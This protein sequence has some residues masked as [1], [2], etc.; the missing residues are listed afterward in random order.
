MKILAHDE[1]SMTNLFFSEVQRHDRLNAFLNLIEWRHHSELPFTVS[2][3]EIH[4]Q[5]NLSEFARPDVTIIIRDQAGHPHIIIV[6]VK[7][8]AYLDCC[9]ASNNNRFDNKFNSKLN[10][11]LTLR[12]RAMQSMGSIVEKDYIVEN[13]HDTESPY[14][15]DQV[16]RCKKP[17]TLRLFKDI[18][19]DGFQFYLV[20]LTSDNVS[21]LSKDALGPSYPCFPLLYDHG[22]RSMV[23]FPNLGSVSWRRCLSLFDSTDSHFR[24]SFRIHFEHAALGESPAGGPKSEDLFVKGRQIVRYAEKV[25]HLSCKGYSFSIRHLRNGRFVEIDRGKNDRGKF[26]ALRDQITVLGK[27]PTKPIGDAAF[28]TKFFVSDQ[29][30]GS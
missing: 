2:Q 5:V 27:A 28:W 21:P 22:S 4:Q 17:D 30:S 15:E 19:T 29:P 3:A 16:R 23:D 14:H 12:Y 24:D 25:C 1:D 7:L 13:D 10:N 6:E 26:L 8:G 18:A 11:Q 20:A 9:M